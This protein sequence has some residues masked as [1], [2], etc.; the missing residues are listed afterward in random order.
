MQLL[1]L[2]TFLMTVLTRMYYRKR[3]DKPGYEPFGPAEADGNIKV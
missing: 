3:D 2:Q 1:V